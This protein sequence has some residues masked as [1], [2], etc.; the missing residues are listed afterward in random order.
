MEKKLL[1]FLLLLLC[2]IACKSE[3]AMVA[4]PNTNEPAY[5]KIRRQAI[6]AALASPQPV[7]GLSL[8]SHE[9][10]KATA[11]KIALADAKMQSVFFDGKTKAPLLNEVFGI[12]PVRPTDLPPNSN[13]CSNGACYRVEIYNF[14]LNLT[15]IVLV[16]TSTNRVEMLNHFPQQQPDIPPHLAQLALQIAADSP[17]VQS[18]YGAKPDTASGLMPATKTALNRSRC[19]RSLHLCVAPTFVKNDRALW[20]IVDLTA[21]KTVGV[22]WT[23]VGTTGERASERKMQ[24]EK[25]MSCCCD[26]E[27]S[28]TRDGWQMQYSLTRS[29]GLRVSQIRYQNTPIINDIKMVDWHVSYST[30]DGFGY[31]DAIGC[32][33]FSEA[34]VVAIN[35][36]QVLPLVEG[37]DTIGFVIEQTYSSEGWPTPC[38]YNYLQRF[39]FHKNGSFRPIIAS[40]GRGCGNN[41]T[42]RPVTRIAWAGTENSFFEWKNTEWQQW[43]QEKWTQQTDLTTLTPEKYWAKIANKNN[44]GF[45]VVAN[46]GQLDQYSRGD[47]AYL[48]VTK[49]QPNKDE[50]DGDLP[51]IGPCCNTDYKQGPEKFIEPQPDP[52]SNTELVL[53]YVAQLK[54]DDTKGKE[55]CW[56]ESVIENGI[57]VARTFPCYSGAMFVPI[58]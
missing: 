50:G 33:E 36:P 5:I 32:P 2:I 16:N 15:T 26:K 44:N 56:A 38:N 17:E 42:Y 4:M 48:Y 34:A 31:S 11:Q 46:Q 52:I 9:T 25:I 53:W 55:Y 14:A 22:R 49:R 47:Q 3:Q 10:A 23:N 37:S 30:T 1:S 12:Y 27:M 7:I 43:Q 20:A 45:Y 24:N 40:L 13:L 58:K 29:D 18:E 51:T 57:Y 28:V 35:E 21:L 8:A 6:A 19:E 54:N 41:G 39:E